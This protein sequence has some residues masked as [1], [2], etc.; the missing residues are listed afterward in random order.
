MYLHAQRRSLNEWHGEE[1]GQDG[2]KREEEKEEE[3]GAG[4]DRVVGVGQ[5]GHSLVEDLVLPGLLP[6]PGR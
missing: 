2:E 3:G 1:A 6:G 5:G 4:D